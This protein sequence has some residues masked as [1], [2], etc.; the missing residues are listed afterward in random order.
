VEQTARGDYASSVPL[1]RRI[2][3]DMRDRPFIC[4]RRYHAAGG[5]VKTA[6]YRMVG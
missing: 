2:A 3:E 5:I 6:T 4:G 1:R